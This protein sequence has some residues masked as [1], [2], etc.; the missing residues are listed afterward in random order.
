MVGECC[1]K[2]SQLCRY[3]SPSLGVVTVRQPR[4]Y[5][6]GRRVAKRSVHCTTSAQ[7]L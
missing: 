2:G 4:E 3:M 6:G 1:L 5:V 7:E